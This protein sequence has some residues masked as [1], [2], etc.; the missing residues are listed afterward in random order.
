MLTGMKQLLKLQEKEV[1]R[2]MKPFSSLQE[3][4]SQ[5]CSLF[6][7]FILMILTKSTRSLNR[8]RAMLISGRSAILD[9]PFAVHLQTAEDFQKRSPKIWMYYVLL[10]LKFQNNSYL[11]ITMFKL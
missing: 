1:I 3:I 2:T 8:V 6:L 7:F 4:Q 9:A 11:C 5:A 10:L